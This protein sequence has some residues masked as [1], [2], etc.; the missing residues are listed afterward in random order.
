[1]TRYTGTITGGSTE[2]IPTVRAFAAQLGLVLGSYLGRGTDSHRDADVR[3]VLSPLVTIADKYNLAV[4]LVCHVSK[5]QATSAQDRIMGSV[6]F[7]C[8]HEP[9]G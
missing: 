2:A 6:A 1:M 9:R 5:S 7:S 8:L 3:S 4:V